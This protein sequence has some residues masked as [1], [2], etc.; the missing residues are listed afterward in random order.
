MMDEPVHLCVPVEPIYCQPP[1][2]HWG[3]ERGGGGDG[4]RVQER[5]EGEEIERGRQEGG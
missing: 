4:G 2:C 3:K 1:F 5:E